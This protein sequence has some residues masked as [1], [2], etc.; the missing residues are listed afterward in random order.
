MQLAEFALAAALPAAHALQ[1]RS[2]TALPS[3][4]IE[5]PGLQVLFA[6]QSVEDD[7]S[8]SQVPAAQLS[9]GEVAPAQYV[10]AS[11]TAHC[12]GLLKLPAWVCTVPAAQLPCA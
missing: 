2:T 9:F 12:V 8:L 4:A 1:V 5:F 10:P 6:T 3:L 7:P 11:H